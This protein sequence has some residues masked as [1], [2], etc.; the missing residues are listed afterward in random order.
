MGSG[1]E[2]KGSMLGKYTNNSSRYEATSWVLSCMVVLKKSRYVISSIFCSFGVYCQW[3]HDNILVILEST[4]FFT[5]SILL[6]TILIQLKYRG[7]LLVVH[8]N[9]LSCVD[10]LPRATRLLPKEQRELPVVFLHVYMIMIVP[11]QLGNC[12]DLH[13]NCLNSSGNCL[14][15][16]HTL[17]ENQLARF[18]VLIPGELGNS[19]LES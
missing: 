1:Y 16:T 3:G 19:G 15:K 2:G 7:S 12:L 13:M 8:R 14:T 6:P 4:C 11:K 17:L 9:C 10:N 18:L 5:M